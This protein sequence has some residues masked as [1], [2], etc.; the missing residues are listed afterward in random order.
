MVAGV[1]VRGAPRGVV[2]LAAGASKGMIWLQSPC[3]WRS[4]ND[5]I[6]PSLPYSR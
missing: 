4:W 5:L 2:P 1:L 3:P 6:L